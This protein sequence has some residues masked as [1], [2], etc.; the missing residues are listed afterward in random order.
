MRD[1]DNIDQVVALGVDMLGFIFYDRS[2]RFVDTPPYPTATSRVGVFVNESL[3]RIL[4]IAAN[5]NLTHIQLH[6][7]EGVELCDAIRNKDLK[8]IKAFSVAQSDDFTKATPY[9]GHVDMLLFDTKCSGYGG[10]GE[11]FDWTLL[12]CYNGETP[13][14]LS[15]GIDENSAEQIVAINHPQLAGVDLNSRFENSPALKNIEKLKTF[16]DKIR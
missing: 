14:M 2:P 11:Q 9:D 1:P 8:V 4:E 16:I 3:E 15:G 13:F 6:G 12:D 5:Y 10:S 7:S